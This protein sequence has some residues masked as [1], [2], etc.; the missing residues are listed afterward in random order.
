[1]DSETDNAKLKRDCREG[2][3]IFVSFVASF[4]PSIYF[5]HCCC[6]QA[7]PV[8]RLTT[9]GGAVADEQE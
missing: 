9:R 7:T 5:S 3:V 1:M 4:I 6:V 2:F 8:P